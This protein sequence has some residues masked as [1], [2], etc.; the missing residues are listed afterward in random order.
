MQNKDAAI[1]DRK[2]GVAASSLRGWR[3]PARRRRS[4]PAPAAGHRPDVRAARTLYAAIGLDARRR[5]RAAPI[6][7]GAN[8]DRCQ[9]I[10]A[11]SASSRC[12]YG[13]HP[14][15]ARHAVKARRLPSDAILKG[16]VGARLPMTASCACVLPAAMGRK[17]KPAGAQTAAVAQ[18]VSGVR[19]RNGHRSLT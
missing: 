19:L 14:R 1:R 4:T 2:S 9:A 8:A 3:T 18:S 17:G 16:S 15:P 7:R 10:C 13:V 6:A 12:E 5:R 11:S